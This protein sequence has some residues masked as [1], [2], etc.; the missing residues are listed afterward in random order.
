MT[1]SKLRRFAEEIL[2]CVDILEEDC[3]SRGVE[4]PDINDHQS[5][6]NDFQ[7]SKDN[8]LD[9]V[10]SIV[11][12]ALALVHSVQS[13]IQSMRAVASG[14]IISA[15]LRC[16]AEL[17]ITDLIRTGD[18]KG[19][20]VDA[21]AGKCKVEAGQLSQ[22]LR[23]L[24]A[25][26]IY[27]EISPDVFANNR[28]SIVL[29][30]GLSSSD[31]VAV[32]Q[33][34]DKLYKTPQSATS[35]LFCHL[36]DEAAKASSYLFEAVSDHATSTNKVYAIS[37]AF[38]TDKSFWEIFELP[39]QENRLRRFGLA[40]EGVA[41][42]EPRDVVLKGYDWQSI[43]KGG[44]VVDV[45]GG[46]GTVSMRLA[47]AYPEMNIVIQDRQS[48]VEDGLKRWADVN[49]LAIETGKVKLQPH[50]FF[51][52]QP[53]Q[54]PDVF[55]MKS[56]IHDWPDDDAL[57]IL[58]HLRDAAGPNTKLFTMDK[59]VPYTCDTP[60]ANI[61]GVEMTGPAAGKAKSG[62]GNVLPYISSVLMIALLNGQE[63][64]LQHTVSLYRKAGWVIYK[65]YQSETQGQ[66]G[67]QLQARPIEIP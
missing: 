7:R 44:Q 56:I 67:S 51:Q 41:R 35:A 63:R 37:R 28:L 64:T 33:S 9:A 32:S 29:D 42:T 43:A 52:P 36:M 19:T 39:G 11:A 1:V 16:A 8:V 46:V 61:E 2:R 5:Y 17:N 21:L 3:L 38:N 57:T 27:R 58:R 45:G 53:I 18:S 23:L 13:P 30:R 15:S 6:D 10:N 22:I 49:P 26:G 66:F 25:Q 31:L 65:V 34:H 50:D 14:H 24:S 54:S 12:S 60:D 40:M 47:S 59:V 62:L 4:V 20:H 48:V 55:F